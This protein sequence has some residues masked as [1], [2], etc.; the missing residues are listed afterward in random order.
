[1]AKILKLKGVVRWAKL[2]EGDLDMGDDNSRAGKDLKKRGG[3]SVL[4][5]YPI[6]GDIEAFVEKL[7]ENEIDMKPLGHERVKKDK[8]GKEFIQL[9]RYLVGPKDEDGNVI[10]ALSG[11]VEVFDEDGDPWDLDERGPIGNGSIIGCVCD[12]YSG[13]LRLRA[14]R[15]LEHVEYD[16]NSAAE[17]NK[18]L[19]ND[20]D[21]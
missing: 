4:N 15:V 20:D 5:L 1:M 16:P 21:W 14:V 18:D 17:D 11:P 9:K 3:Q 2:F 12:K 6:D 10:E 7:V 13:N 19:V 8:D